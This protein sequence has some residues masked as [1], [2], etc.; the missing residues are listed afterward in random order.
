MEDLVEVEIQKL[1]GPT[2]HGAAVL[3]GN[4]EKSFVVFIGPF[5]AEAIRRELT[6]TRAERPLTHDLVHSILIGFDL[7]VRR[8]VIT[9]IVENAFCATLVLD[10]KV[11]EQ[12]HAWVGRRNE[13]RIDARPSDCLVLA[14]KN[15]V[16]IH[17]TRDVF[18]QVQD[19]S[20]LEPADLILEGSTPSAG[21][22]GIEEV[23]FLSSWGADP[24]SEGDDD[25]QV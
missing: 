25:D 17:V 23:E 8:V 16:D 12:N 14:L 13:V 10:Q 3:L 4:E 18:D 1:I 6:G 7:E 24:E 9:Q 15:R 5:E 11:T 2:A 19:V 20:H 21:A 22:D